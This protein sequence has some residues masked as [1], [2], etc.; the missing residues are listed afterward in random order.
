[1]AESAGSYREGLQIMVPVDRF[2]AALALLGP[3]QLGRGG[4]VDV[5]LFDAAEGGLVTDPIA[6]FYGE[7]MGG[8]D[9]LE[10][11]LCDHITSVMVEDLM[12][13]EVDPEEED[14]YTKA[15]MN[16]LE[17]DPSLYF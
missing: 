9:W 10:D 11:Y 5:L 8:L 14:D 7:E 15:E 17:T 4:A 2:P 3:G 1:M 12:T 16:R 13:P 6:R